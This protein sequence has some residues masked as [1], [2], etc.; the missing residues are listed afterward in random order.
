MKSV[1]VLY[2]M[3]RQLKFIQ[4]L[5]PILFQQKKGEILFGVNRFHN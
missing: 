4:P 5:V 2:S 1:T 3:H